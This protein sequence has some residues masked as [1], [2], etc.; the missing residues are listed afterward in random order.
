MARVGERT[1]GSESDRAGQGRRLDRREGREAVGM[2]GP[3]PTL[4]GADGRDR[5]RRRGLGGERMT[6][7]FGLRGV[8]DCNTKT[9]PAAGDVETESGRC[10][11]Y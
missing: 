6:S 10:C 7:A 8:G 2:G 11:P 1:K 9:A 4:R 3:R 5:E